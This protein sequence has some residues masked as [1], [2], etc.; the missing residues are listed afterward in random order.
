MAGW[1]DRVKEMIMGKRRNDYGRKINQIILLVNVWTWTSD[2]C[3]LHLS[4]QSKSYPLNLFPKDLLNKYCECVCS[5]T[6]FVSD[7]SRLYGL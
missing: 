4:I 1:I 2:F 3:F 5:V 7:S 6:S